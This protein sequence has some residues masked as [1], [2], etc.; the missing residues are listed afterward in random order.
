M[1]RK[2][3]AREIGGSK[4]FLAWKEW[5]EGCEVIGKYTGQSLDNYDKTNW[6]I[7]VEE[8]N[9]DE[10]LVGKTM[11]LN[12]AGSLDHKMK[13]VKIGEIVGITY[14]GT[15]VSEKGKYAGKEFHDIQVVVYDEE[16]ESEEMLDESGTALDGVEGIL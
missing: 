3:V 14:L 9:F 12:S 7:S 16:G 10:S 6:H 1:G 8:S 5:G 11:G 4:V 13:S 15:G 2:R